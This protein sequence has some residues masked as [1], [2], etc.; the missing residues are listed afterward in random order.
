MQSLERNVSPIFLLFQSLSTSVIQLFQTSPPD[1][2]CWIIRDTG[3]LCVVKDNS[4]RAYFFRI[5][6]PIRKQLLWQQEMYNNLEYY[7]PKPLLHTFEGEDGMVAFNFANEDEAANCHSI[8]TDLIV[9]RQRKGKRNRNSMQSGRSHSTTHIQQKYSS[10]SSGGSQWGNA[11]NGNVYPNGSNGNIPQHQRS[12]SAGG[13]L[14]TPSKQSISKKR[15]RNLTTRDISAP[16]DFKHVSHVGWDARHG[17]NMVDVSDENLRKFFAEAGVSDKQLTD[18][19]TRKFIYDF[20]EKNGGM[21]A[22]KDT[23]HNDRTDYPTPPPAVPPRVMPQQRM[24]PAPPS[25]VARHPSTSSRAAP[26]LPSKPPP[27]QPTQSAPSVPPPPPPIPSSASIPPP[28]PPPPPMG[29]LFNPP[30]PPVFNESKPNIPPPP[31]TALPVVP[32][33]R[34]ALLDSI[35]SGIKLKVSFLV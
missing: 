4:R 25:R 10:S 29:G 7:N 1:H 28:P 23:L 6:C 12:N 16:S 3:V 21:E 31:P 15:T 24:A 13:Q 20:L 35:K 18:M 2:S 30:N 22:I 19:D 34:S 5:Y 14:K 9:N 33:T 26:S 27:P 32:D 17:F 8:V 11:S